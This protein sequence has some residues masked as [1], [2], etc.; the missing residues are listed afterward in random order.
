MFRVPT[1][2]G[3]DEDYMSINVSNLI[4]RGEYTVAAYDVEDV[5]A[6]C[7]VVYVASGT[8][9]FEVDASENLCVLSKITSA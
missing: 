2:T 7:A 6:G 1:T 9:S 8:I 5:T 4:N 3:T